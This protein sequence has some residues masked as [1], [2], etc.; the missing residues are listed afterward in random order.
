MPAKLR[1]ASTA[2]HAVQTAAAEV[3]RRIRLARK[4]R[5]L[6][7]R[8]AAARAGIAYDTAGAVER[9]NLMTGFGAYLALIWALGLEYELASF[10]SPDRDEEGKQLELAHMPERVRHRRPKSDDDF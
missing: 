9:G 8:E 2:P 4:R 1:F 5:R 7:L 6:T 10:L 3:G